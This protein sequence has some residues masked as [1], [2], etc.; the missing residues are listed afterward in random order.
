MAIAKIYAQLNC[1]DLPASMDWY[2]KLFGRVPDARP[3]DGLAEWH[4]LDSAGFQLFA[5][6]KDAGHGTL[7]LLV[8]GLRDE[9]SRLEA[10]GLA[11][12]DIEPATS[13]SLVRLRDPDGNLVV[14][15]Q[16]GEI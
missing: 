15:A 14:L 16:P 4:H 3:M 8:D 9:H 6:P 5:N 11:P 12:G 10:A 2:R 13:T 7:T 1:T